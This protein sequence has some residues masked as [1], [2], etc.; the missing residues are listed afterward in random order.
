MENI[1]IQLRLDLVEITDGN[2]ERGR[3]LPL[4]SL[5]LSNITFDKMLL[6]Y[7]EIYCI[8]K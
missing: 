6:L 4:F 5:L 2:K 3:I 7:I 1:S 8:L